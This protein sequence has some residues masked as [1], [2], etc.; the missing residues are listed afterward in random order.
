MRGK[1][2]LQVL[3]KKMLKNGTTLRADALFFLA[4]TERPWREH[5]GRYAHSLSLHKKNEDQVMWQGAAE[6][7]LS[8]H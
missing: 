6:R 4:Q 1:R 7:R 2:I 3:G 8:A 5:L